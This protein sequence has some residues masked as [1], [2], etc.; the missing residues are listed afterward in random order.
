MAK[1]ELKKLVDRLGEACRQILEEAAS[2][3]VAGGHREVMIEHFLIAAIEQK[4]GDLRL[5]LRSAGLDPDL[6]CEDVRRSF[7]RLRTGDGQAPV[8]SPLLIELLEDAWMVASIDLHQPFIRS[9]AVFIALLSDM[10]RFC[11]FE[12]ARALEKFSVEK[13]RTDFDKI[14]SGSVENVIAASSASTHSVSPQPEA[15]TSALEKYA[16]NF[17]QSAR[18]GK[19]DPVFCR[20]DE[21]R[22]IVDILARRRKNNPICVG[23]AGVGKTAVVEG[24]ALKIIHDD[25]PESLRNFEIYGLDLGSLQAGASVKGEFEKR[26]KA[27]LDEVRESIKPC[28]LFIDEAHTLIGSGG[29]VGGSDAANLLK[30]ALARGEI[31]TIAATTWSEYK[32]YFEKDPA[33]TRRFQLVKL[34]EPTMEQAQIIIRGLVPAYEK[35][36]GDIYISEAGIEAAVRLSSRYITGRQL[37]DKAIDVLDTA[38]ARVKASMTGVPLVIEKLTKQLEALTQEK[39][40]LIRDLEVGFDDKKLHERLGKLDQCLDKLR[41]EIV[42]YE[43][44]QAAQGKIVQQLKILREKITMTT[45]EERPALREEM[46]SLR[47]QFE[48]SRKHNP[49]MSVEVGAM[50]IAHV[51]ADW[52]GIPIRSMQQ[53]DVNNLLYLANAVG[54]VIKGQD[55]A[56]QL[57]EQQLQAARLD[58][59]RGSRP[60]GVFLLV[61]PSGVGKTETALSVARHLFGGE[62]FLTTVNMSEFQEKHSLSR[63]IGSPPGY[64][65]YGEGGILTE[66]IR[67][68]PYSVV[69]LDEV[70]KAELDVLNLFY[71]AFDKGMLADGEGRE[72]DCKNVVFF[73]CSNLGSEHINHLASVASEGGGLLDWEAITA[74]IHPLLADH[75]R[76][77]LLARMQPIVYLPLGVQV[78]R[79][80][81]DS[82]LAVLQSN[83]AKVQGIHFF[84]SDSAKEH[85]QNL[86]QEGTSGARLVDQVIARH[87][88]PQIARMILMARLEEKDLSRIDMD[89]D[90]RGV[91]CFSE[92][93][94]SGKDLQTAVAGN[95]RRK[96]AKKQ[97][98]PQLTG[99]L[100]AAE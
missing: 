20:D 1:V 80:I 94:E 7:S 92:P 2:L 39:A 74:Q 53:D 25:V 5:L 44:E 87:I 91:F 3:T 16:H 52:T 35:A 8:F 32:K 73:L 40:T 19:I 48:Q 31:K 49:L 14:T 24:L 45:E 63:L 58:L 11:R 22:Q 81:I 97:P 41:Q 68:K 6:L 26:L 43:G 83:L 13:C 9:G 99:Q 65:G 18:D 10:G 67:K 90:E 37:P 95:K 64:V 77:A 47:R 66:A 72:I 96:S 56:L 54:E 38:C 76:P 79:E 15:S 30:P 100:D 33:L 51:I 36:H 46:A 34:D 82:K 57:I 98:T 88:L 59:A 86:C 78:L 29:Q 28:V 12:Y 4:G 69:L 17:T 84:V 85:L 70:E 71:Q 75:F 23:E 93:Q 42:Q 62:Q 27:V 61:G 60:L 89:V 55:H 50:E 21:I